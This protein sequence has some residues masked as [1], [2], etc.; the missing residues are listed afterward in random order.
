MITIEH[1]NTVLELSETHAYLEDK[2]DT[3]LLEEL[4]EEQRAELNRCYNFILSAM[5]QASRVL[6]GSL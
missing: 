4:T 3:I 5:T 2:Q 1:N 6:K